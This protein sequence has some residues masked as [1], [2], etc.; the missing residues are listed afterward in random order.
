MIRVLIADDHGI[1]RSG[2]KMLID[3]QTDMQVV[4]EATD[5]P[6]LVVATLERARLQAVRR[7]LPSLHH[8]KLGLS[9]A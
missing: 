1:V 8:R 6:G 2:L 7:S 3:R 5:G 4:A 9:R